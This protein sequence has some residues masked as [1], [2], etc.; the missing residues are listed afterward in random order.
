MLSGG[1]T[2]ET[3]DRLV[4]PKISPPRPKKESDTAAVPEA[5]IKLR[6]VSFIFLLGEGV[7]IVSG[8]LTAISW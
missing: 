2:I 3:G 1:I 4:W 7:T 8:I 5:Q 6:R